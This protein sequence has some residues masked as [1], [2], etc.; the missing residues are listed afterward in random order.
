MSAPCSSFRRGQR[1][2]ADGFIQRYSCWGEP[3]CK[4]CGFGKYR[5]YCMMDDGL[6]GNMVRDDGSPLF[7]PRPEA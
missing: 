2:C 1:I 4:G 3:A 5:P 7:Y 6:G